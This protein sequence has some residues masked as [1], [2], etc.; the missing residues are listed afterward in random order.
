M[1]KAQLA[2][3]IGTHGRG[4]NMRAIIEACQKGEIEAEVGLVVAP[5]DTAPAIVVAE[6][7]GVKVEVIP[8]ALEDYEGNLTAALQKA[9]TDIICLAGYM[10]L[11][12]EGVL[13]GYPDRVLN[14]HPA[15]L[16]KFGG[17]GMYGHHVHEAVVAAG[18]TESGC[19]VHYVNE[20]YDE[21]QVILQLK[22]PIETIDTPED[23]AAKVLKLEHKAYPMAIREVIKRHGL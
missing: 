10:K 15:L 2:I 14:I 8:Y 23:V 13:N 1:G 5:K 21:G 20:R 16:P 22:T 17:K 18:E 11:L 19:S 4:S 9:K 3:L 7:L 6:S 12:P